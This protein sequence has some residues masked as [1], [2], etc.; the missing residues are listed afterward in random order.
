MKTVPQQRGRPWRSAF[1]LGLLHGLIRFFAGRS[2]KFNHRLGALLGWLFWIF[3]SK[4]RNTAA[5][6]I[7]RCLPGLS[8]DEQAALTRRS[9]I[10]TGKTLT[11]LGPIWMWPKQKIENLIVQSDRQDLIDSAL[12][13]GHGA[14][15]LAPHLGAWELGGLITS[16]HY[17]VTVLYRPPREP[18]FETV[19]N[20]VRQRFGAR[21]VPANRHGVKQLL[22]A[23]RR[24]ELIAILPDQ[25]PSAGDGRFAPF[26]GHPA[27]TL[28]LV[29]SLIQ[30]TGASALFGWMERLPCAAGFHLHF[31][32]APAGISSPDPDE[33]LT[34]MN[35]GLADLI[36]QCPE[37]YQWT[38]RRFRRQPEPSHNAN[39]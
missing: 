36:L 37:Q 12:A 1:R 22:L 5:E 2:L 34:A 28:S 3:G 20:E 14:I 9:L 38:Y 7:A 24:G 19:L 10:E 32:E 35:A 18:A 25:E 15:L 39:N 26:F 29:H 13:K 27:Y 31:S 11:E 6:N 17:P 4:A 16:L 30:N 8:D 23:L 21:V 33:S